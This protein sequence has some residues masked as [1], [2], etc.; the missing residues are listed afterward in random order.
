[1][2]NEPSK[3][4]IGCPTCDKEKRRYCHPSCLVQIKKDRNDKRRHKFQFVGDSGYIYCQAHIIEEVPKDNTVEELN[5]K[6]DSI[7]QRTSK[8]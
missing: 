8:T 2:C 4:V 3:F 1:M 6:T 7:S 5:N